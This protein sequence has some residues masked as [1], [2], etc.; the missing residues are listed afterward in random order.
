MLLYV[1]EYWKE[2]TVLNARAYGRGSIVGVRLGMDNN[3]YISY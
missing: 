1:M 2:V 3:H